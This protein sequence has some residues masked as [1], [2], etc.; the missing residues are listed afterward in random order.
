MPWAAIPPDRAKNIGMFGYNWVS[1]DGDDYAWYNGP[2]GLIRVYRPSPKF[3]FEDVTDA[4]QAGAEAILVSPND[5]D[6]EKDE[7]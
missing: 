5:H 3:F 6:E 2:F 1:D 7:E 4:I